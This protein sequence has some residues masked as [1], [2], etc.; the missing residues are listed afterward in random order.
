MVEAGSNKR[1]DRD[2]LEQMR[3][4]KMFE[5]NPRVTEREAKELR[6]QVEALNKLNQELQQKLD[7]DA[8]TGLL[9]RPAFIRD[10]KKTI[11]EFKKP[12]DVPLVGE[13]RKWEGDNAF[14]RVALLL[15]DADN[16]KQ[17]NTNYGHKGGDVALQAIARRLQL[18]AP[19]INGIA[20]RWAGD[21][22]AI[23]FPAA[24]VE[25]TME[26]AE[27]I[28]KDVQLN[29]AGEARDRG[30]SIPLGIEIT[31]SIGVAETTVGRSVERLYEQVGKAL[32]DSKAAGK[33]NVIIA[34]KLD[35]IGPKSESSDTTA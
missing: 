2:A 10:T 21:E 3:R 13:G 7:T 22:F 23:S 1:F 25:Q 28:R 35:K 32:Q 31:I 12:L 20:G 6:V 26:Y 18:Q 11:E 30:L 5:K 24:N 29:A 27:A 33:N 34:G 8:L 4:G 14:N 16:F 19:S 17:Y 15:I 9:T